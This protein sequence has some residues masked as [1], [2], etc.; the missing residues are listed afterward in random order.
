MTDEV[1]ETEDDPDE[2]YVIPGEA[3][4]YLPAEWR[5]QLQAMADD[6]RAILKSVDSELSQ[7]SRLSFASI[8]LV[9]L[10]HVI[11]LAEKTG[12]EWSLPKGPAPEELKRLS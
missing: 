10:K 3:I 11:K 5:E 12:S 8:N 7:L 1:T 6:G 2:Y 9:T 4:Q